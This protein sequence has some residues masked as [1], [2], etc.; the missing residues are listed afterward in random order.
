LT[1]VR[2]SDLED[3]LRRVHET[4][5]LIAADAECR[6]YRLTLDDKPV[7]LKFYPAGKGLRVGLAMGEFTRLQWLQKA[8]VNAPRA[9]ATLMGF[10]LNGEKGDALLVD[11]LDPSE[12][13]LAFLRNV[14]FQK[15]TRVLIPL[16][17]FYSLLG[18]LS[19]LA[20]SKMGHNAL[21]LSRFLIHRNQIYLKDATG[22]H[23]E[24]LSLDELMQLTAYADPYLSRS[25]RQRAWN[26]L[27]SGGGMPKSNTR[28]LS[29]WHD[30]ARMSL[31]DNTRF[32]TFNASGRR[33]H[34]FLQTP[35]PRH[36]SDYSFLT[37]TP[38]DWKTAWS[39]LERQ[40]AAG[41]MKILKK[42]DSGDV[43]E[44]NWRVGDK[45]LNVIV[46]KPTPK[47]FR[48]RISQWI[49]G[50][51]ARRAWI[52]AWEL[53]ERDIPT[54]WPLALAEG[55]G[56][57]LLIME[58]VPGKTLADVKPD[59]T[60]VLSLALYRAGGILRKL[61]ATGLYLYDAKAYN[62]IVL[63]SESAIPVV[64][65][66]DSVRRIRQPGGFNRL[67][68]SLRDLHGEQLSRTLERKLALGYEPSAS[69]KRLDE[70]LG[71]R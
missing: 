1:F 31:G 47:N 38:D 44:G 71:K 52:K 23:K 65:D 69:R 33:I 55:N 8:G 67:L 25:L 11:A 30:Q 21:N 16:N 17:L 6:V 10:N 64:I 22:I 28:I 59:Q 29:L 70:L 35:C 46:K 48:R 62:W 39:D 43:L 41:E 42:S 50:P 7:H 58:K 56:Q 63:P 14:E 68:R 3:I 60:Q 9:L 51:R 45:L 2:E 53:V 4:G 61:E 19:G 12:N 18:I 26:R 57:S 15:K 36:W 54:A 49:L 20:K 32:T 24:G 40:L 13:L 37:F 66:L 27:G 5:V 34:A